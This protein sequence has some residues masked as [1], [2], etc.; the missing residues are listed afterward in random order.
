ML[1]DGGGERVEG[2]LQAVD[3]PHAQQGLDDGG[4]LED[5]VAGQAQH[6]PVGPA[7]VDAEDAA[8]PAVAV[9]P[10]AAV[11]PAPVAVVVPCRMS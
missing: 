1:V 6:G 3:G 2:L 11:V 10:P 7:V 9:V 4:L 5:A 8:G